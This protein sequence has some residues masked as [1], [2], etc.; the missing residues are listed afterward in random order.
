MRLFDGPDLR[1]Q[2]TF[3][4]KYQSKA[5]CPQEKPLVKDESMLRGQIGSVNKIRFTLLNPQRLCNLSAAKYPDRKPELQ[6]L[7]P[8]APGLSGF[9]G[10]D[11][12]NEHT[13]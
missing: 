4:G 12:V 10:E 13:S 2:I 3:C 9:E 8:K 1:P 6:K 7:S 11:T 5:D